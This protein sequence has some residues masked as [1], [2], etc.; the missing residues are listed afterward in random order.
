MKL[1]EG[2]VALITGGSRGIGKAL[3]VRFAAEGAAV[4]F[5]DLNRDEQMEATENELIKMGAKAKG[6]GSNAASLQDSE[7]LAGDVVNDFGRIDILINNAG[8]TRDNLLMRMTE[9]DWDM[10]LTVNLKSVFNLTKAVQRTM[11]KQRTGSII[12]M[13]SVVGVNGNA[14]QSNYSAS[15]AGMI[16][17]TKSMAAELGSRNVRCNAIAP[18]FIETEM[19]HKLPDDVRTQWVSTIPLRRSGKPEDVADVA[20]FLASELS[21]YVTGQ[22][23]SVCGGMSM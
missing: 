20:V 2:K 23:I 7:K 19:T 5:S 12:N 22:V 11:I 3:A 1:L 17:F 6:Y 4:A 9:Q 16:G 21:A 10:V 13:S 8:I 15:K 18:G 14:G